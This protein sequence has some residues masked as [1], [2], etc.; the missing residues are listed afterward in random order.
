MRNKNFNLMETTTS[1]G[2]H[3]YYTYDKNN[4]LIK[5]TKSNRDCI[6]YKYDEKGNLIERLTSSRTAIYH[7]YDENNNLTESMTS[8]REYTFYKYEANG[9]RIKDII[10]NEY[11]QNIILEEFKKYLDDMNIYFEIYSNDTFIIKNHLLNRNINNVVYDQED[12]STPKF[13]YNTVSLYYILTLIRKE[14]VETDTLYTNFIKLIESSNLQY[15]ENNI[16]YTQYNLDIISKQ[17]RKYLYNLNI[18]FDLIYSKNITVHVKD[19]LSEEYNDILTSGEFL[20]HIIRKDLIHMTYEHKIFFSAFANSLN[21]NDLNFECDD[22]N[23]L[24]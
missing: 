10:N 21:L 22:S 15:E 7:T 3:V 20:I 8:S 17:F 19:E 11:N 2:N 16:S 14:L 4:K 23:I 9:N 1:S 24:Y 5:K 13:I 12:I 18:E 6:Y